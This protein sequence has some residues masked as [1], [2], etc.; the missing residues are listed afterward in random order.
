VVEVC[1]PAHANAALNND[2]LAAL[3]MPCPILVWEE[4]GMVLVSTFDTRAMAK[5][6]RGTSMS[7]V[8][9][10]VYRSLVKILSSVDKATK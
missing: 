7:T 8:G 6:Y 10:D 5:M 2:V 4:D 9:E 1:N 3:M